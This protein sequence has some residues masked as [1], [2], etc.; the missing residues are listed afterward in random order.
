MSNSVFYDTPG[1]LWGVSTS[2]WEAEWSQ[3]AEMTIQK[4]D[5]IVAVWI[6]GNYNI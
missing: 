1:I 2:K 5:A 3:V 6:G 4:L